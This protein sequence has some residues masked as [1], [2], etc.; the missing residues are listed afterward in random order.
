MANVDDSN[1]ITQFKDYPLLKALTE[2]R[3]R[4]FA[5]GMTLNGGPLAFTSSYP[6]QPLSL[7]QE[8]ILAFAA[9]GVTGYALAELPFQTGSGSE[10]GSGNIMTHFIAR[11]VASGDAMHAVTL[12]VINDE[13]TWMV[14]RP[15][16]HQRADIPQLIQ[17]ARDLKLL[18]LYEESRIRIAD[19][20]VDIPRQIPYVPAFNK[21]SANVPGT[22]YFLPVNEFTALYIN[23]LLSAFDDDFAY[24]IV[25][26]ATAS[27]QRAS[28]DLP[29]PKAAICTTTSARAEW[30]Q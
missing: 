28:L 6:S 23:I 21:W 29:G 5:K 17:K 19:Q 3:S 30:L 14:K 11:T 25:D 2:R 7:E 9:C 26:S 22:T 12:F 8:A 1:L 24:F 10:S 18:E 4:R 16:D 13:G 15:Q 20:R 27:N